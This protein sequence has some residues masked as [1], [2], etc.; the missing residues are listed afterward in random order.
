M[1]GRTSDAEK[2]DRSAAHRALQ[3]ALRSP[4]T[5]AAALQDVVECPNGWK[6]WIAPLAAKWVHFFAAPQ[7]QWNVAASRTLEAAIRGLDDGDRWIA[8]L[9]E[10]LRAAEER[11]GRLEAE[12][13]A[14]RDAEEDARRKLA[15]LGVRLRRLEEED[16][17]S[18][19]SSVAR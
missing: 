10:A 8:H 4:D 7:V 6:R 3:E 15:L 14:V 16:R 19:L 9:A 13:R 12:L 5:F 11:I 18:V 2:P 1:E 17:P